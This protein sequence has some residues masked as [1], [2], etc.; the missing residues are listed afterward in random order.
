MTT[1][2]LLLWVIGI[3]HA[4]AGIATRSNNETYL[5]GYG[6]QYQLEQIQDAKT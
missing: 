2:Q 4:G 6:L 3:Q 5:A 1:R